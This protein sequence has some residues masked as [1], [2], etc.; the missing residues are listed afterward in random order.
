[1]C[2]SL[3]GLHSTK[4]LSLVAP[5]SYTRRRRQQ[6]HITC[7]HFRCVYA[8]ACICLACLLSQRCDRYSQFTH[9]HRNKKKRKRA[10]VCASS[11]RY[12]LE[13]CLLSGRFVVAHSMFLA[14]RNPYRKRQ[15]KNIINPFGQESSN[16]NEKCSSQIL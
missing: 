8:L 12:T 9:T 15:N 10:M 1:M 16:G 13:K 14:L 5:Q 2:L 7:C 3:D 11:N 6:S 4:L